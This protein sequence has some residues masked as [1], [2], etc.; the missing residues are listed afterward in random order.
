MTDDETDETIPE[1]GSAIRW[2]WAQGWRG[3]AN[4]ILVTVTVIVLTYAA[5]V[6]NALR[7]VWVDAKPDGPDY[8]D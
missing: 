5:A 8:W 3:K 4:V 2:A 6:T 7:D 1:D